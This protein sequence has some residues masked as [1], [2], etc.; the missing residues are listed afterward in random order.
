M[1]EQDLAAGDAG[2]AA[3]AATTDTGAADKAAS[4]V[5]GDA[6]A[7]AGAAGAGGAAAAGADAGA[8]AAGDK[9]GDKP[10][11]ADKPAETDW[12]AEIAGED[13]AFAKQ[14]ERYADKGAYFRATRE[15]Q[16]KMSAGELKAA[17]TP[18]PEKGTDAEK[19]EWRKANG[20]HEA[21]TAYIEALKLP[22]GIVPGE[23]DKPGL[24]RL[25]QRAQTK[26]WTQD[27][28]NAVLEAYYAEVDAVTNAREEADGAF[29]QEAQDRLR[30]D[31]G[32]DFRANTNA[33]FNVLNGAPAGVKESLFGGRTA[34]GRLVGDDPNVMKWL[35]QLGR[36]LNPAAAVLPQGVADI[37]GVDARLAEI[38]KFRVENPDKYDAD[39]GMQ[40]EE[41]K[42]IDAQTKINRRA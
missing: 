26:N 7:A 31:W 2:A 1:S 25:A 9:A 24:E 36:D 32:P 38:R 27:Q 8:A 11:A 41:L 3:A 14:L 30:A 5:S 15:L 34:E 18:F 33:A 19:A 10:A 42:L 17:P 21:P 35:A 28:Y 20:V 40:S 22:E 4:A 6:A 12:R 37:K 23:A 29:H 39:K 13:K 16:R